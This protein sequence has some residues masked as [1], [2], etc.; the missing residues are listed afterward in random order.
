MFFS[1]VVFYLVLTFIRPQDFVQGM[2]GIPLVQF[3]IF[4][5]IIGVILKA[6][7]KEKIEL[8]QT[9]QNKFMFFFWF[10]VVMSTFAVHWLQY[11][12][13]VFFSWMRY[14][15]IYLVLVNTINSTKQMSA[16]LWVI[17]LS[18]A[19]TSWFGIQ[20]FYGNDIVGVGAHHDGRIRGVGIF[21]TN[22]LAYT[23]DFSL[24]LLIG[25][26]KSTR[27]ILGKIVLFIIGMIYVYAVY[28]TQSRGGLLCLISVL[29]FSAIVFGKSKILKTFAP[30]FGVL[31]VIILMKISQRFSSTFDYGAD[32]SAQ[33]RMDIWGGALSLLKQYPLFGIGFQQFREYFKRTAHSAYI[34]CSTELGLFGFFCWLAL[35]YFCFKNIGK[36]EQSEDA[37]DEPV[38][39][40]YAKAFKVALLAYLVGCFFSGSTYYIT[41]FILFALIVVIRK[42]C[43]HKITFEK[44]ILFY[45]VIKIILLETGL[46]TMI[47][48]FLKRN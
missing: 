16:A 30:G 26:F 39:I 6:G 14:V 2:V 24:A 40:N 25:L 3:V 44:K 42:L 48:L 1:L 36:I 4:V 27:N 8:I 45:D 29:V 37:L 46:I 33:V 41:L 9:Q 43:A 17:I 5:L 47:H 7:N 21:D 22:Q 31:G 38:L 19:M 32:E 10:A 28:L 34:E 11:T 35:F 15:L 23:I 12:A 13:D 20:Q 18:V